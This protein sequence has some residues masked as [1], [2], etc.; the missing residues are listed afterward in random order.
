MHNLKDAG[1]A[2]VGFDARQLGPLRRLANAAP[3][4]AEAARRHRMRPFI[5]GLVAPQAVATAADAG[6][7]FLSGDAIQR[8]FDKVLAPY[9]LTLDQITA[10]GR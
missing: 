7:D 3:L 8:P 2:A 6:F 1:F 10:A 9:R 5:H 4:F